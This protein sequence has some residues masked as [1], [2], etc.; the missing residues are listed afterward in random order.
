[1]TESEVKVS[2]ARGR[3]KKTC[4]R[5][6]DLY[7]SNLDANGAKLTQNSIQATHLN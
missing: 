5:C 3:R 6:Y 7:A 4:E 1:M 2:E